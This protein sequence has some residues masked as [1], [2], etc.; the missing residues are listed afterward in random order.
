M[1][2]NLPASLQET[3]IKDH[4]E[5]RYSVAIVLSLPSVLVAKLL[6]HNIS[7]VNMDLDGK[8]HVDG[9]S[10]GS[11][12]TRTTSRETVKYVQSPEQTRSSI[13]MHSSDRSSWTKKRTFCVSSNKGTSKLFG[14]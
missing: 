11:Q 14:F 10:N 8:V 9:T 13:Y 1:K 12:S 2:N 3:A 6:F 5:F 4:M 7:G